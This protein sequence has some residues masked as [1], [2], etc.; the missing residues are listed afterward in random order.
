MYQMRKKIK[1]IIGGNNLG[2]NWFTVEKIDNKT[3]SISEY[4]HWENVHSYLVIG[5][6]IA[7]LIDTGLGIG[8]IKEI[9][10][11]L[12]DLPIKVITTHVH[13]DHIGGHSLYD[14]ISV[15]KNDFKWMRN[16]IPLPIDEIKKNLVKDVKEEAFPKE[17]NINNYCLFTGE[18]NHIL[19]DNEKIDLGGRELVIL[20]TPGHSSG[21]ICIYERE[22]GYLYTGDLLYKGTLYAFYPSTNPVDFYKSIIKISELDYVEKVLPGHNDINVNKKFIA[23]VRQAFEEIKEKDLLKH[24]GGLHEYGSFKIKL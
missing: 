16:G 2:K 21:H 20:H 14:D 12:T 5:S 7:C 1:L 18:P 11:K 17:F 10:D 23:E 15:H 24:G 4:N 3:F 22:G 19:S 6:K 8:N 9:T 13:W